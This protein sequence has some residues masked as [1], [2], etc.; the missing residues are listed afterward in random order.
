M[1]KSKAGICTIE[2][3]PTGP[4]AAHLLKEVSRKSNSCHIEIHERLVCRDFI[5]ASALGREMDRGSSFPSTLKVRWN[6]LPDNLT[7][8]SHLSHIDERKPA[9]TV[10]IAIDGIGSSI[11]VQ[12]PVWTIRTTRAGEF[13]LCATWN[14][15]T[16]GPPPR[17]PG[18]SIY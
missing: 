11:A 13:E 16:L 15:P 7:S 3:D 8:H 17:T 6:L 12:T 18:L 5:T 10:W 2:G 9:G 14:H 4:D 1:K